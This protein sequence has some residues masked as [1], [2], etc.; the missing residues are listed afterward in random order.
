MKTRILFLTAVLIQLMSSCISP[1]YF[2]VYKAT[3]SEKMSLNNGYLV[4]EDNNCIVSY[5]LWEEGGNVGFHFFNK[6]DQ[7]I[8]VNMDESF[9]ILNG[10]AFDYYKNRVFTNST[11]TGSSLS[12]SSSASKS[13]TG[14]N[15]SDLLQ[16]NLYSTS[17]N[18]GIVSATGYSTSITEEKE[19]KVPAKTSKIITEYN[20]NET[21]I[22]DCDLFKYPYKKQIHTKT[23]SKTDSPLVF[24]NRISYKVGLSDS[25]IK[26]ENE[27]YV[28]EITNYPESEMIDSRYDDYC[29]E[30]SLSLTRYY[31]YAA[32]D[33]FYIQYTRGTD[34]MKH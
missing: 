31:K 6:T 2:Q 33:K 21:L 13:V 10:L 7:T 24:S 23:F 30:K 16:T 22:R 4:Y 28:S 32:P 3:P 9:F 12:Y 1:A 14:I 25:V 26:F 17:N 34:S 27:F 15:L 20:I 18:R 5:Y 19:I 8:C 11:N 29:G